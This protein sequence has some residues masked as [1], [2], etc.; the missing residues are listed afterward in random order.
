VEVTVIRHR[1]LM[2]TQLKQQKGKTAKGQTKKPPRSDRGGL[3]VLEGHGF[4]HEL[5]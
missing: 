1:A 2:R 3:I 4:R 5:A